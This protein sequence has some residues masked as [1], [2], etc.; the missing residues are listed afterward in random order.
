MAIDINK[1][2]KKKQQK[3]TNKQRQEPII[4]RLLGPG[5]GRILKSQVPRNEGSGV[6]CSGRSDWRARAKNWRGKK[7]RSDLACEASLS[8]RFRCKEQGMRVKDRAKMLPETL[9]TQNEEGK[10]L[11]PMSP[12]IPLV[13]PAYDLTRSPPSELRALL[14]ECLQ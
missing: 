7:T 9:A 14:S 13:F 5:R 3:Q 4:T 6:A 8:V 12:G 2:N 1:N 11:A 10:L